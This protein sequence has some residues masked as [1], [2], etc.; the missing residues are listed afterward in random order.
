MRRPRLAYG[1]DAF[2]ALTLAIEAI[3][4]T[5]DRTDVEFQW[6]TQEP[7]DTGF[8]RYLDSGFGLE[9]KRR[10]ERLVDKEILRYSM[11]LARKV[12]RA[13]RMKAGRRR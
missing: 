9:L 5:L 12:K 6:V 1:I 4:K 10:L 13:R 3:R 8:A 2:Q 7:G 11:A